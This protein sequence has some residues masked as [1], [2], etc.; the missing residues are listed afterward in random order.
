MALLFWCICERLDINANTYAHTPRHTSRQVVEQQSPE[1]DIVLSCVSAVCSCQ[2]THRDM[3]LIRQANIHENRALCLFKMCRCQN[4]GI[5]HMHHTPSRFINSRSANGGRENEKEKE[6]ERAKEKKHKRKAW[7]RRLYK[8]SIR[9]ASHIIHHF[10]NQINECEIPCTSREITWVSLVCQAYYDF[11]HLHWICNAH[12]TTARRYIYIDVFISV[13][14]HNSFKPPTSEFHRW[15]TNKS[16][17]RLT[18]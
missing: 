10:L 16:Y 12:T 9:I 8:P 3:I 14:T 4:C 17:L 5:T 2:P 6:R 11:N 7:W 1:A 15:T 13:N 18:L